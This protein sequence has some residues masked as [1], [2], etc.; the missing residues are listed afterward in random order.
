M[1]KSDSAFLIAAIFGIL[2]E[3]ASKNGDN[4]VSAVAFVS[5]FMWTMCGAYR[6]IEG[7]AG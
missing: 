7:K 2:F 4:F 1:S 6:W 5:F 3:I